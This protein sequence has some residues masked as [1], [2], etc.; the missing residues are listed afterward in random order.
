MNLE[1]FLGFAQNND[2]QFVMATQGSAGSTFDILIGW[3]EGMPG[4]CLGRARLR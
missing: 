3:I 2:P 1:E 4:L